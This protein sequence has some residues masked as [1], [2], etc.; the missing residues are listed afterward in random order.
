MDISKADW[1]LYRERVP[2][3][4]EHYMEKLTEEYV[5]LLTSPGHASDHFWEYK[6]GEYYGAAEPPV[7]C[8]ESHLSGLT[9]PP[10]FIY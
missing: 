3:W 7:R 6:S 5:K 2:D 9:E 10:H 1:K 8:G 4:Q